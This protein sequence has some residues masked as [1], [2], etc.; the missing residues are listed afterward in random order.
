M[1]LIKH[2]IAQEGRLGNGRIWV[3]FGAFNRRSLLYR[4]SGALYFAL[5]QDARLP[6]ALLDKGFP[7][8]LVRK[9]IDCIQSFEGVTAVVDSR[10]VPP[11]LIH[12]ANAGSKRTVDSGTPHHHREGKPALVELLH[13]KRHLLGS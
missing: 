9:R 10:L 1:S 13:T 3:H 11:L 4:C 12:K 8:V 2:A 6:M 5:V 7:L